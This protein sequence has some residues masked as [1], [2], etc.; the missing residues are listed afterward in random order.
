MTDD[1]DGY[2][3]GAGADAANNPVTEEQSF[4][5]SYRG[6]VCNVGLRNLDLGKMV[7][8]FDSDVLKNKP[9]DFVFRQ[10]NILLW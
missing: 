10:A 3:G 7:N 2:E 1:E 9:F 8:G 4:A 6:S 5:V